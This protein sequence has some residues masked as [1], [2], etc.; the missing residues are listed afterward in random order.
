VQDA[1]FCAVRRKIDPDVDASAALGPTD[2]T[3]FCGTDTWT[4]HRKGS[5]GGRV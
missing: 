4:S 2:R 3:R 1:I 5:G